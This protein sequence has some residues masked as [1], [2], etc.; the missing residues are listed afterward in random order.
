MNFIKR[1]L[2]YIMAKKVKTILFAII[3][4]LLG[5]L[6]IIGFGVSEA[7]T[8][9]KELARKKMNPVVS[10]EVDY[11][12]YLSDDETKYMDLK[13]MDEMAKDKRVKAVSVLISSE[14]QNS[15]S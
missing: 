11:N 7:S 14:A 2:K 1:S 3:F 8:N 6:V 9:A 4:L 12:S 5:N 13:L 10:Y 15:S